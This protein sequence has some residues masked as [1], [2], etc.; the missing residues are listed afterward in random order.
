MV[1]AV[2]TG[3]LIVILVLAWLLASRHMRGA[4][5]A[6][7]HGRDG[8]HPDALRAFVNEA[9]VVA[10]RLV[11]AKEEVSASIRRLTEIADASTESEEHLKERSQKAMERITRVFAS[12]QEVAASAAQIQ[13]HST[14]MSEE[15]A[16]TKDLVLDVCRSLNQTDKVMEGLQ[17]HQAAMSERIAELAL[18]ASNIEE[19]NGFIREVVSQT[20][21]L[22]LNASIEA[23]RA[24]EHGRGFAVVAQEIKKLAE[25]SHEAVTRSSGIL[26]SVEQGVAHVV[27]AM[28]G[29]KEA[30]EQSLQEMVGM[31]SSMDKIL[32]RVLQV[33]GMVGLTEETSRM[34]TGTAMDS[35]SMLGEAVELVSETLNGI[36]RA[37]AMMESQRK[38][39]MRMQDIYSNLDQTSHEMYESLQGVVE[40]RLNSEV[41]ADG[42]QRMKEWL[43]N[44][45][46]AGEL[47]S[48]DAGIHG[49]LLGRWLEE[50]DGVEAIW[51]NRADGTFLYS[52]PSAGLVN[53]KGREW[54][55]KA[56]A[57]G[58]YASE[59]YV[60]AI[61]KKPCLTLSVGIKDQ[62]GSIMG[63]LGVDLRIEEQK[64]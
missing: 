7:G 64:S 30:V 25:Q 62:N 17:H 22:A 10:D 20:S 43:A 45:A 11:A 56:M 16:R 21:L 29:E 12:M 15:S 18:H 13:E 14:G 8:D 23:A 51:S 58:L 6:G 33:D 41:A 60:S 28:E 57:G 61:T 19:I 46:A 47:Q 39:I 50:T 52:K 32:H 4:A 54:W 53:A 63:V 38:Q 42:L 3:E 59:V 44:K 34:Q 31:K 27:A 35:T 48:L 55:Q 26:T 36:E 49:Q 40:E 9:Q 2:M 24:G 37:V 1:Y 5:N